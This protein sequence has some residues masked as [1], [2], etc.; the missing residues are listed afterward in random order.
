MLVGWRNGGNITAYDPE[1]SKLSSVHC[2]NF[3]RGEY[4]SE[5]RGEC[6]CWLS[7]GEN[8]SGEQQLTCSFVE[9]AEI[10]NT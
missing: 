8:I 1:S 9:P 7:S 10:S 2:G 5:R 3:R 4:G 6:C